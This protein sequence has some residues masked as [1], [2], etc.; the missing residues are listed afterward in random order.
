MMIIM[1]M[2]MINNCNAYQDDDN[3]HDYHDDDT[4]HDL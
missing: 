4:Y 3:Y 2:T 1:M